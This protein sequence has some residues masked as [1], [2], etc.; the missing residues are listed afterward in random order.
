MK[1]T[2]TFKNTINDHLQALANIDPLFAETLNKP[3]KSLDECINYIF[4]TVK[5]SGCDGFADSEIYGMAV[6]Y[7]DEDDI[8]G[9]SAVKGRVVVNHSFAGTATEKPAALAKVKAK[10]Q[11]VPLNQPSLF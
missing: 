10:K 9:V 5:A 6:H 2:D 4:T 1:A 8:K 11:I 3:N 7:Y